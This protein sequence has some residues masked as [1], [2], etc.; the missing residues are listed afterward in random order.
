MS[1][2]SILVEW[3]SVG[4]LNIKASVAINDSAGRK[5]A[6]EKL[7]DATRAINNQGTA[8]SLPAPDSTRIL[9]GK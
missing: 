8:L 2:G 5:L 9:M 1:A 4:H 3:D 7:L 6:I